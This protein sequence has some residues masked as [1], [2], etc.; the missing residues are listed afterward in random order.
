[1][2]QSLPD[3]PGR[4]EGVEYWKQWG[5]FFFWNGLRKSGILP[6]QH[7]QEDQ[8]RDHIHEFSEPASCC[9][10]SSQSHSNYLETA[11][12]MQIVECDSCGHLYTSPRIPE[13]EWL[14]YLKS[15]TNR[16]REFTANRLK[17]GR[18]LPSNTKLA[19][20]N[21][22]ENRT[23]DRHELISRMEI[24]VDSADE[25]SINRLHD[26]GCGVG[27]TLQAAQ[28]Q[29]IECSGNELNAPAV[30]AMRDLYSLNVFN[31]TLSNCELPDDSFDAVVMRDFIEH[32]YHPDEDVREAARI[33]RPG[34]VL[35]VE[36]FHI[37][38]KQFNEQQDDWPFLFWNHTNHFS[39]SRLTQLLESHGLEIRSMNGSPETV[40]VDIMAQK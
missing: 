9:V 3:N 5:S 16:S 32:S 36:T 38:A 21:W 10:C 22:Y 19:P 15:D 1:M 13:E 23:K 26:V 35:Y 25:P 12:G 8:E 20:P 4:F 40:N 11:D 27:F 39:D 14:D 29:G 17:Y 30:E 6:N 7:T 34:G 31:K 24:H 37:N 2:A 28:E 18:A 33:L